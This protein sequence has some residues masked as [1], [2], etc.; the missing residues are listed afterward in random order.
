MG[1]R[2]SVRRGS[3]SCNGWHFDIQH[4]TCHSGDLQEDRV[5]MTWPVMHRTICAFIHAQTT[6]SRTSGTTHMAR[7]A[8]V[9][10]ML[11]AW[12]LYMVHMGPVLG[13][14]LKRDA[15]GETVFRRRS[16]MQFD[17]RSFATYW[18]LNRS[19]TRTCICSYVHVAS[20]KPFVCFHLDSDRSSHV[21][22][23]GMEK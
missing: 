23:L 12:V 21:L 8:C 17:A 15:S 19:H 4:R 2:S 22:R 18:S 3:S 14:V 16:P 7:V 9:W 10:P 11:H 6:L 13:L 5:G 1:S 20:L